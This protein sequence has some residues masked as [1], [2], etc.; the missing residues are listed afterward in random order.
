MRLSLKRQKKK[1][2]QSN[3]T[4]DDIK[5]LIDFIN[6]T[7]S[8]LSDCKRFLVNNT[9]DFEIWLKYEENKSHYKI[10]LEKQKD[11]LW[12]FLKEKMQY[13]IDNNRVINIDMIVN[14]MGTLTRESKISLEESDFIK[15][16]LLEWNLGS[17]ETM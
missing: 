5:R 16:Q 9:N 3:L 6:N 10:F 8:R 13:Q 15:S 4:Q 7:E 11:P 12:I 17:F 1:I 2:K 14:H